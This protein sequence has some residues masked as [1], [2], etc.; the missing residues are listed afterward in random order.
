MI[1][2]A[3]YRRILVL[4][5]LF[6][7]PARCVPL[8]ARSSS[9]RTR[10]NSC[11]AQPAASADRDADRALKA[12]P[13]SPFLCRLAMNRCDKQPNPARHWVQYAPAQKHPH[14]IRKLLDPRL[15]IEE[16]IAGLS[17][18]PIAT[19][20][21][22]VEIL[23]GPGVGE[24]ENRPL[25]MSFSTNDPK[26]VRKIFSPNGLLSRSKLLTSGNSLVRRSHLL[27]PDTIVMP[28]G[29]AHCESRQSGTVRCSAFH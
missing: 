18:A 9:D 5:T 23:Q 27:K 11:Y 4:A 21:H 2:V 19:D 16:Q 29:L 15:V 10:E 12:Q 3:R 22:D 1:P 24:F 26:S 20:E 13:S 6:N 7:P 25:L 17:F 28:Q 8:T 14:V